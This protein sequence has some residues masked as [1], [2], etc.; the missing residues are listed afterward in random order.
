VPSRIELTTVG[1][2]GSAGARVRLRDETGA[3]SE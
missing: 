3:A 1:G 2:G